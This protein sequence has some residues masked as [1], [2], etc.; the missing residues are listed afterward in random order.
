MSF[1]INFFWNFKLN[2]WLKRKT[3]SL[4]CNKL[5]SRF[6]CFGFLSILGDGRLFIGFC[7][8]FFRWKLQ[9]LCTF[10][11]NK[12]IYLTFFCICLTWF[13][14][15]LYLQSEPDVKR[16]ESVFT[17][18]RSD[19]CNTGLVTVCHSEKKIQSEFKDYYD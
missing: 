13:V 15:K 5:Y 14:D 6:I 16:A 11:C 19:C 1:E 18:V 12:I 2:F 9:C 17:K 4:L 7:W 10:S 3:H 8:S